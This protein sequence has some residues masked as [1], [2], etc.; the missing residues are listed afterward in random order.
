MVQIWLTHATGRL[1]LPVVPEKVTVTSGNDVKRMTLQ[2]LGEV[3]L[4]GRKMLRTL[5]LSSYFPAR[6]DHNCAYPDIPRP[7]DAAS[8]LRGWCE[9]GTA[10]LL[11]IQGGGLSLDMQ[12]LIEKCDTTM[13][14]PSGDIS[15]DMTLTEHIALEAVRYYGEAVTSG[16]IASS[17]AVTAAAAPAVTPKTTLKKD[18]RTKSP[19]IP[20]REKSSAGHPLQIKTI[21][22]ATQKLT[23]SSTLPGTFKSTFQ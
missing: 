4:P 13:A 23:K 19:Y 9:A 21:I 17:V 12:V 7:Q 11:S 20:P 14:R 5:T 10:V 16:H 15:Y 6:Y 3:V 8:L 1:R 2:E 18:T 22:K